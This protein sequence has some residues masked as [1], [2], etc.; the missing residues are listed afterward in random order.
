MKSA[1]DTLWAN[2]EWLFSGAGIFI[3]SGVIWAVRHFSTKHKS[4]ADN[5]TTSV[6]FAPIASPL[7]TGENVSQHITYNFHSADKVQTTQQTPVDYRPEPTPRE[8]FDRIK[9]LPLF[10][11]RTATNTYIDLPVDWPIRLVQLRPQVGVETKCNIL[12][13]YSRAESGISQGIVCSGIDI[14]KNPRLKSAYEGERLR[15]RGII[16]SLEVSGEIVYLRDSEILFPET[17]VYTPAALHEIRFDYLPASPLDNGWTRVSL[18]DVVPQF[19][20]DIEIPGSLFVKADGKVFAMDYRI[21]RKARGAHHIEFE[22]EFGRDAI[23]YTEIE[24]ANKFGGSDVENWW[25]AHVRGE[26]SRAP[27]KDP[28]NR[29]WKFY[30]AP[31]RSGQIHFDIDVVQEADQVLENGKHFSELKTVRLRGDIILSPIK[32][33]KS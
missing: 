14:S 12:A 30:I 23:F 28:R 1:W 17:T 3:I 15:V 19:L 2:H 29:E 22:G 31:N 25:F 5:E 26:K 20:T 11:Q 6:K 24:V 27:E 18:K 7:A 32:L 4:A 10:E 33:S 8:I 16:D 21:P 13:K 9:G